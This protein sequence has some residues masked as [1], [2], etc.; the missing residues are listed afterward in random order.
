MDIVFEF[1]FRLNSDIVV[2]EIY[3]KNAGIMGKIHGATNDPNPPMTATASVI[4][5]MN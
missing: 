2:P 5:T 4:S 1:L 3:A